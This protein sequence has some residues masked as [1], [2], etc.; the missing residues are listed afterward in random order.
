MEHHTLTDKHVN[1]LLI[2]Q[3]TVPKGCVVLELRPQGMLIQ[4]EPDGRLLTFA[5]GE[6][7]DVRLTV[8]H[9]GKRRIFTLPSIINRVD[10]NTIDVA[11]R[12]ANPY[13]L[14]L[15][16]SYHASEAHAMDAAIVLSQK[17]PGIAARPAAGNLQNGKRR[18]LGSSHRNLYPG[19]LALILSGILITG[20]Y[21]Y[22]SKINSRADRLEDSLTGAFAEL[23]EKFKTMTPANP[24]RTGTATSTS[25]ALNDDRTAAEIRSSVTASHTGNTAAAA[26]QSQAP[27]GVHHDGVTGAPVQSAE[28]DTYAPE[29]AAPEIH[30]IALAQPQP[31]NRPPGTSPAAQASGSLAATDA[32]NETPS[33]DRAGNAVVNDG[34]EGPPARVATPETT[35][36]ASTRTVNN[37]GPWI[38]NLLSSRKRQDAEELAVKA[39]EN[40]IPVE[41]NK[42]IIKGREYWRL[43]ITGFSNAREARAYAESVK[44]KLGIEEVWIFRQT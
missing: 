26:A 22:I 34:R 3:K 1:A 44:P 6:T 12:H 9:E 37:G 36:P 11:Y 15:I 16:K 32:G 20:G 39:T 23:N 18:F 30:T 31:E 25:V 24:V 21:L 8:Q 17:E 2:G 13:L 10:I 4:C 42:A 27:S 19:I 38:I 7:V 29:I 35:P 41:I 14:K 28:Q 40:G 33:R 5:V 43:Q